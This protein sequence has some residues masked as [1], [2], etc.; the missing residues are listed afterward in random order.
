MSLAPVTFQSQGMFRH[1]GMVHEYGRAEM[2]PD[3]PAYPDWVWI[4]EGRH[5][6]AQVMTHYAYVVREDGVVE[7][8]GLDSHLRHT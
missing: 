2:K 5:L 6:P 1:N 7:L 3:N 4:I 8:W